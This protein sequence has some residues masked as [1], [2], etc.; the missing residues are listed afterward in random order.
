MKKLTLILITLLCTQNFLFLE[1]IYKEVAPN[2]FKWVTKSVEEYEYNDDGSYKIIRGN[3]EE[4]YDSRGE[5]ITT[6]MVNSSVR[7]EYTCDSL[8]ILIY[9]KSDTR[10]KGYLEKFCEYDNDGHIIYQ[11]NNSVIAMAKDYSEFFYK[12][13]TEGHIIYEKTKVAND[14][15]NWEYEKRTEYNSHGDIIKRTEKGLDFFYPAVSESTKTWKYEYNGKGQKIYEKYAETSREAKAN[16]KPVETGRK[17]NEKYYKYEN[18]ILR[19]VSF[20][21]ENSNDLSSTTDYNSAGKPIYRKFSDGKTNI[22]KYDSYGNQIYYK[23][24]EEKE[25][26]Y[27]YEYTTDG[28]IKKRVTYRGL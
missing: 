15:A 9:S 27:E 24:R 23:N 17:G 2:T 7:T 5:L 26:W 10:D 11:K 1:N 25:I 3:S 16:E 6:E 20:K 19:S 12:Y 8:G 22:W 18:D 28:K 4:I 13:D 14:Y 21:P